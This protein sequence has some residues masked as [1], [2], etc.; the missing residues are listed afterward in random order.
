VRRERNGKEMD[1]LDRWAER[2][3]QLKGQNKPFWSSAMSR[4]C[5]S[6][7]KQDPI[8]RYLRQFPNVVSIEGIRWAE[9]KARALKPRF[10]VREQI[11]TRNRIAH[12]WNAII[13]YTIEQVWAADGQ[14]TENLRQAQQHY[15][16]T[17]EVPTWWN[18][19]PAYAMGNDRL[20]C[21]ICVLGNKN[22][23]LNGIKHN[24]ELAEQ[25]HQWELET[26]F[27]FKQGFSIAKG[28]EILNQTKLI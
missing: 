17:G 23:V 6:D 8:N 19:H 21:A 15:K 4:Y 2:K 18:Y 12:T 16:A 11:A 24:P 7:L 27:T 20:S 28:R 13:D 3:E 9:S 5:T 1:L 10:K 25:M 14:S 22:D 26:G